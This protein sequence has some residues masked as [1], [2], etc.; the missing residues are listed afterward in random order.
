MRGEMTTQQ[1]NAFHR[2][3]R[4]IMTEL[5]KPLPLVPRASK[6]RAGCSPMLDHECIEIDDLSTSHGIANVA[7]AANVSVQSVA[8]AI[9]RKPLFDSTKRRLRSVLR[10]KNT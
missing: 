9:A 8:K 5:I 2:T 6:P 3:L 1:T 10:V 4:I 7:R